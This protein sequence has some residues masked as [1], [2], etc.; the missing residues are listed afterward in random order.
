MGI[1]LSSMTLQLSRC[2][3]FF[4]CTEIIFVTLRG[5]FILA[6]PHASLTFL[7]IRSLAKENP[8]CSN[9]VSEEIPTKNK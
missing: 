1:T 6:E 2:Y 4:P 5:D 3:H 8:N 9:S 7:E